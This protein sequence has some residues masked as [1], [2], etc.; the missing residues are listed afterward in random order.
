MT[1]CN[2]CGEKI[3]ELFFDKV[4]GTIIKKSGSSKLYHLCFDCQ[5]K[6]RTKEE[7][8]EKINKPMWLGNS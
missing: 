7:Q 3:A 8:L 2:I 1:K 6:F 4:K 5:K